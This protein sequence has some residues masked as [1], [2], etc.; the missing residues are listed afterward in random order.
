MTKRVFLLIFASLSILFFYIGAKKSIGN[1]TR[2]Y[3]LFLTTLYADTSFPNHFD[4]SPLLKGNEVDLEFK[5]KY[6]DLGQVQFLFDNGKKV[7]NDILTFSI[8]EKGLGDWYYSANYETAKMDVGQFFPFGFPVIKNS[9]GKIYEIRISSLRGTLSDSVSF[10]ANPKYFQSIY[11]FPSS[12]L[13]THL[14]FIPRFLMTKVQNY[15]S[16]FGLN[17]YLCIYI[18]QILCEVICVI[19]FVFWNGFNLKRIKIPAVALSFR[20]NKPLLALLIVYALTHLQFLDY[21]QY[22]DGSNY[23]AGLVWASGALKD[24][25]SFLKYFNFQGHPSMGYIGLLSISQ[26]IQFDN[27]LLMNLENL[28]LAILAIWAFYHIFLYFF[29]GRRLEASLFE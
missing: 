12:Y 16:L 13:R 11:S 17:D 7:N 4:F 18:L 3:N 6:D 1:Y 8:R 25:N 15:L 26:Y 5:A 21:S 9:R 2:K 27:V 10:S 28:L 24:F 19:L 22:W 20:W 23:F 14:N 29:E